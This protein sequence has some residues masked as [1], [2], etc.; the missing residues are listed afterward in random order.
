V[1]AIAALHT[2]GAPKIAH[3]PGEFRARRAA[4][5]QAAADPAQLS[6]QS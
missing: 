1:L 5:Q 4:A 2:L 3:R 6:T